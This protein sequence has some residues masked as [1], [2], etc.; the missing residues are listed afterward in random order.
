[1]LTVRLTYAL[2][3]ISLCVQAL[4]LPATPLNERHQEI[5]WQAWLL[6][7]DQ[8]QHKQSNADGTP[9]RHRITTKSV[10]VAPT[11]SAFSPENLPPCP[12]GYKSDPMGRC[13]KIIMLDEAS[14]LEFLVSKLN[15]KFGDLEYD[16]EEDE[17]EPFNVNIPLGGD[18][19]NDPPQEETE[20][21]IIVTPT[22][23]E[24]DK[25]SNVDKRDDGDHYEKELKKLSQT[26]TEALYDT[27]TL[28]GEDIDEDGIV[29]TTPTQI[30]EETTTVTVKNDVTELTE[31][32]QETTT[33]FTTTALSSETT[34]STEPVSTTTEQEITTL[35]TELPKS[36][37]TTPK[38]TTYHPKATT[39]HPYFDMNRVG[40]SKTRNIIKFPDEELIGSARSYPQSNYVRFPDA[41]TKYQ[42]ESESHHTRD[43][44]DNFGN[45]FNE[46]VTPDTSQKIHRMVP[47]L[48]GGFVPSKTYPFTFPRDSNH[49][50]YEYQ[51]DST[52]EVQHN[53]RSREKHG[54][55]FLLP[56]KWSEKSNPSPLVLRSLP[57]EDLSVLFG[58]SNEQGVNR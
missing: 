54:G 23:K 5:S 48:K 22:V 19:T 41:D 50:Q 32:N 30:P 16:D 12:D 6:V 7:D 49:R 38:I 47:P 14:H 3:L 4:P 42:Q 44:G 57:K 10:F 21:A 1:M 46:I 52:T 56:P 31:E 51:W 43:V 29:L 55:L 25:K 2:L 26:T 27:T 53:K 35:V 37:T 13:I 17:E 58:Y 34:T 39:Y 45:Y 20:F 24:V 11:F 18:Y 33:L 28:R 8:N 36:S 15:D 9:S 40:S